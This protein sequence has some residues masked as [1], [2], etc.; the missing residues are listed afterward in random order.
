MSSANRE[1]MTVSLL[2][3]IPFINSSC[4][5]ALARNSRTMLTRIGESEKLFSFL[6]LGEVVSVF[7]H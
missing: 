6:I 2:M 4:L 5:T 1:T 3:C 7:L